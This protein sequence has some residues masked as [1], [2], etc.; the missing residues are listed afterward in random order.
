MV[1][2]IELDAR[3]DALLIQRLQDHVPGAVGSVAA[4][5]HWPFTVVARVA[6]E[7]ALI[8]LPVWRAVEREPHALQLNHCRDRF[9][10]KDLS[11]ILVGQVVTTL[12]GVEHVPLPVVLF[13]IAECGADTALCCARV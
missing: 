9:A 4:A 8:N 2:V 6:T 10:C 1:L 3:L 7:T 13:N 11:R 5:S 12:D